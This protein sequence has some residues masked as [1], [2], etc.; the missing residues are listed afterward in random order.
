MCVCVWFIS[1]RDCSTNENGGEEK[2]KKEEEEVEG[3]K[4]D[5]N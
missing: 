4:D 3:S 1:V 5:K 2:K